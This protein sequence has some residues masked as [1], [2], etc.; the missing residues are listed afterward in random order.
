MKEVCK[1]H[2]AANL[3]WLQKFLQL[4]F[5]CLS[6]SLT[7]LDI[8]HMQHN[9]QRICGIFPRNQN[10]IKPKLVFGHWQLLLFGL[11]LMDVSHFGARSSGD[12]YT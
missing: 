1:L 2:A 4:I 3:N 12:N 6:P 7:Y 10:L 11:L 5:R 8:S 9:N